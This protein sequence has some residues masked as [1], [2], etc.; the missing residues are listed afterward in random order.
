M[1]FL[2][3]EKLNIYTDKKPLLNCRK[4]VYKIW[5]Y[6]TQICN[7]IVRNPIFEFTVFSVIMFNTVVLAMVDPNSPEESL[8]DKLDWTFLQLY[9]IELVL[10]LIGYGTKFFSDK[11]N[12]FD[13]L[14]VFFSWIDFL[15]KEIDYN[16]SSLRVLR[17]LRPLKT[18]SN[19]KKL[20][21]LIMTILSSVPYLVDILVILGFV[22][23]LF[24]IAGLHI[25]S[26]VLKQRCFE[27]ETGTLH[28]DDIICEN[29]FICPEGYSCGRT[30]S[31]PDWG[32]T[33]FD[34]LGSSLLM[35][36]LI[37]TLE[38]WYPILES[39][40]NAFSGF[41]D[42][43]IIMY[44]TMLLFIGSFFILNLTL[45]VIIV[46]FNE[47]GGGTK[48]EKGVNLKHRV[49]CEC[50]ESLNFS[51]MSKCKYFESLKLDPDLQKISNKLTKKQRKISMIRVNKNFEFKYKMKTRTIRVQTFKREDFGNNESDNE[52]LKGIT[53]RQDSENSNDFSKSEFNLSKANSERGKSMYNPKNDDLQVETNT[54]RKSMINSI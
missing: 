46:K 22:Y 53:F 1:N 30:F 34:N 37:T 3:L 7:K 50:V 26:G 12:I 17:V 42:G 19:I 47:S 5:I 11:W 4:T 15:L 45:A 38:G 29:S 40:T 48:T 25:F 36:F 39:L 43:I 24:A 23:L 13:F 33:N 6:F 8:S 9:T 31:N 35:V 44:F 51:I 20:K 2:I 32:V 54:F 21:M 14:I 16:F 10:K 18:I 49:D 52:F 41:I 28:V 27:E